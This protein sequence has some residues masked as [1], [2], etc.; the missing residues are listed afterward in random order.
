MEPIKV[1]LLGAGNRGMYAYGEYAKMNPKMMK[2]AAIAEPDDAKRKKI[3][4][5]HKIPDD[6]AFSSWEDGFVNMPVGTEAVIITT[7]DKMHIGPI[8]EA[9]KRNMHILCE[10]PIVPTAEECRALEPEAVKYNKVFII[11]HVL[12]YT[13]FFSKIKKMLHAGRIGKLIGIDLQEHVGHIHMSHSFVRGNWRNLQES[14]PMILAK[15]CHDMD[16]LLW[17]A[18]ADCESLNSYGALNYFK[19][20]NAPPG[21]PKRCLDGCPHMLDCPYHVSKIYLTNDTDW[22][23]NVIT[24]DLSIEGRV[25]A[26]ENGPYGRCVFHC[27][28]N[29]VDHQTVQM[30]FANGVTATFTMTGFS[31]N[32]TRQ[33]TLFGTAGEISGDLDGNTITVKEFSS[34]NIEKIDVAIP[35]G[36]H[37]GGDVNLA[38][39]FVSLIRGESHSPRT[40]A[41]DSFQ[42]HFM[43]FAAEKSRLNGAQIITMDDFK[44]HG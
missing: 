24:T 18:G 31:M 12:K 28:N 10:K 40:T 26:L 16:M 19:P 15:S 41:R 23:V 44:R 5:D 21:A 2:I 30:K 8:R 25:K 13:A 29:V 1:L 3:Q 32:I 43:A 33:I 20:E 6:Y 36:G 14:P 4:M 42:S 39:E 34:R 9:M 27:D 37:S 35:F 17:L 38:T 7:Q 22:P 11:A